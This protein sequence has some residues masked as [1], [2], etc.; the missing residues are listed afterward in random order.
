MVSINKAKTG[1][2][3]VPVTPPRRNRRRAALEVS[4]EHN[5]Y[6]TTKVDITQGVNASTEL[7]T[8]YYKF[9]LMLKDKNETC[10]FLPVIPL[11]RDS[12][13]VEPDNIP[14]R[15]S[16]LMRHFTATSR[17]KEKTRSVWATARLTFGGYF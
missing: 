17:I 9:L 12:A 7:R 8:G 1:G 16:A 3:S 5:V 14:T 15:M 2:G 10:V 13:I 11:T 6:V 4:Y